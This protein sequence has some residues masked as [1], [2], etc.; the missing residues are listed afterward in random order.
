Q[1]SYLTQVQYEATTDDTGQPDWLLHYTPGPKARVEYAAFMR[2]PGAD[3]AA[4]LTLSANADPQDLLATVTREPPAAPPSP[5]VVSTPPA[6][7]LAAPEEAARSAPLPA[8]PL[9]ATGAA[10]PE[11]DVLLAQA[12]ALVT[13]FYQRFHGLAQATAS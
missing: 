3:T 2:Q 8:A 7:P 6:G 13:A 9:D 12:Q 5:A 4:A 10:S 1:S 11:A